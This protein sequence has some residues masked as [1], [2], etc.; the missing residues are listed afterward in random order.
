LIDIKAKPEFVLLAFPSIGCGQLGYDP[1]QIAKYMLTEAYQQLKA[2]SQLSLTI[3]FVLLPT[4]TNVYD[5]FVD[6]L[7]TVDNEPTNLS[8]DKQSKHNLV[9]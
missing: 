5:A 2:H 4:Q 3:S 7:Q 8:F 6:Q 1:K 9:K